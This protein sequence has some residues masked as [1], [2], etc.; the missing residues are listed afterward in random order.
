MKTCKNVE[1]R[2]KNSKFIKLQPSEKTVLQFNPE[3]I[4]QTEEEFNGIKTQRYQ[5]TVTDPN[6]G[7]NQ[8]CLTI[9]KQTFL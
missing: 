6:S 7:S 2:Q 9:A 4:E 1:L 5:Y 8:K 3:K